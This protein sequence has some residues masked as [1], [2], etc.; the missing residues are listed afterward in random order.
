M[1][2]IADNIS[3]IAEWAKITYM[4]FTVLEFILTLG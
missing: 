2:F 1:Q 4:I 3:V